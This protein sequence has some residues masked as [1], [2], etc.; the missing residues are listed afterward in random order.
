MVAAPGVS[1]DRVE[2]LRNAFSSVLTDPGL[3][4]EGAKTKRE[5]EYLAGSDLQRLIDNLMAQAGARLP[6]FRKIVL[7]SY[8]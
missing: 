7:E 1:P 8:F 6:E 3:V 5:I 4:A 2:F